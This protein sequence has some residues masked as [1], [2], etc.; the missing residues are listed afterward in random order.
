MKPIH[1]S[2]S[3][4]LAALS[5][6][7]VL[8]AASCSSTSDSSTT[9]S[10]DVKSSSTTRDGFAEITDEMSAKA[11]VVSIDKATRQIT[12]KREDG[13]MITVEAG[14]DV[15]NFDQINAGD[16]LKARYKETLSVTQLPAGSTVSAVEGGL[17]AGRAKAGAKPGGGVG[18]L[19][20]AR[21]KVESVDK[22][23]S[24]VV[25][26]LSGGELSTIRAVRPEGQEFVKG[27][28]AGDIVQI[29]YAASVALSLEKL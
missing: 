7:A 26:S 21:V 6:V 14:P 2:R 22:E 27:L 3:S 4:F 29:D 8:G 17:A 1:A 16:T 12:L 9:E 19:A 18:L 10:N 5:A 13:K 20:S 23:K 28:K 15:R 11:Q 25:Y 24:I